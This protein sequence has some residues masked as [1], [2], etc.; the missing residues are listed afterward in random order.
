M[1]CCPHLRPLLLHKGHLTHHQKNHLHGHIL[2]FHSDNSPPTYSPSESLTATLKNLTSILQSS[3]LHPALTSIHHEDLNQ[4]LKFSD[5]VC[6]HI[7]PLHLTPI[8]QPPIDHPHILHKQPDP[9]TPSVPHPPRYHIPYNLHPLQ[10]ISN[11]LSTALVPSPQHLT[12]HPR[13][14]PP[15]T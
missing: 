6:P 8:Y 2:F 7:Q 15:P 14:P 9:T 12:P 1:V 11:S 13:V 4:V 5:M 3:N 10:P